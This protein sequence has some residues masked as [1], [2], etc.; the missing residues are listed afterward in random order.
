M[1]FELPVEDFQRAEKFYTTAFGWHVQMIPNFGYAILR[2]TEMDAK[3]MPKE[4]GAI[5]GGMMKRTKPI[6]APVITVGVPDIDAALQ[7]VQQAGGIIVREK[8]AVGT[9]GLA[10][11]I[12]DS[13]GNILGL[14]QGLE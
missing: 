8:L 4:K 9:M 3:Q 7:R 13:E 5:N 14:W 11:Y 6:T 1:H 2:T 12:K 10:A